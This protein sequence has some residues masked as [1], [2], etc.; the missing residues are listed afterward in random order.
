MCVKTMHACLL[1]IT[2]W[3]RPE[4]YNSPCTNGYV[5][6]ARMLFKTAYCIHINNTIR[7]DMI[8]INIERV[9]SAYENRHNNKN[10]TSQK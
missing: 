7:D 6:Y 1:K 2:A 5:Y 9:N 10:N 4:T 8:R 3:S